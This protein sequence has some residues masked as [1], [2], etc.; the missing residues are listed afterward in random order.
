MKT[1]KFALA[2]SV[3]LAG[4]FVCLLMLVAV[5][6]AVRKSGSD[7]PLW[8]RAGPYTLI[9]VFGYLLHSVWF[10]RPASKKAVVGRLLMSALAI[11]YAAM[12]FVLVSEFYFGEEE[13]RQ[14][15]RSKAV[16]EAREIEKENGRL[17]DERT[18]R[19]VQLKSELD[20]ERRTEAR[21]NLELALSEAELELLT[22]L[23]EAPRPGVDIISELAKQ[24]GTTPRRYVLYDALATGVVLVVS[25]Y[26]LLSWAA[27]MWPRPSEAR[28]NQSSANQGATRSDLQRTQ[29][30]PA[31][32]TT[33]TPERS[34]PTEKSSGSAASARAA[35]SSTTQSRRKRQS[36]QSANVTFDD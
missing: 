13:L 2:V 11:P 5:A 20:H 35:G 6:V 12:S 14:A 24:W 1:S 30:E 9:V 31:F 15:A 25:P 28:A 3:S 4:A 27:W 33:N 8:P 29:P 32:S 36:R 17:I 10:L 18:L 34:T 23:P 26:V 19:V 21:Q 16:A 7:L 22:P